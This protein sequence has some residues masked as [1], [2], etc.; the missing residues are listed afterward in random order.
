MPEPAAGRGRFVVTA[1]AG[2]D[3]YHIP[4]VREI[5]RLPSLGRDFTDDFTL[6]VRAEVRDAGG[7]RFADAGGIVLHTAAGWA[8]F[9]VERSPTGAW[10]LVTVVSQPCSDEAA[11]PSLD[12]PRA[13]LTVVREGPRVT[14][15][16]AAGQEAE[17]R[18]LRTF[19]MP[20]GALRVG[21]FAQAPFSPSCTAVFDH[22]HHDPEPLRDR[23]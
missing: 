12:G 4:G 1:A 2:A 5:D 16:H 17:P 20:A 22:L 6:S 11:G 15:L 23:R 21:L 14:F 18:F 13:R 19:T 8:K 7:G 10:T 9:C 3:L